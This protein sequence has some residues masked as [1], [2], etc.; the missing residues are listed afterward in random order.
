MAI[1]VWART[2]GGDGFGT[3][4]T[5]VRQ[6]SLFASPWLVA[7]VG[8]LVMREARRPA[9]PLVTPNGEPIVVAAPP[10]EARPIG[11][12]WDDEG[13]T[14]ESARVLDSPGVTAGDAYVTVELDWRLQRRP[15]SG[16]AV[17]LHVEGPKSN[18]AVDYALLSGELLFEDAPLHK[19]LRDVSQKILVP[20]GAETSE[21]KIFV[22][23]YYARRTAGSLTDV[24]GGTATDQGR[25][26]VGSVR[27]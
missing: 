19:T 24:H 7:A 10:E 18:V 1:Y 4:V 15:P 27:L 23:L 5:L 3:G 6:A 17:S 13:I 14:L 16:L 21:V 2:R 9:P 25:V 11:A 26:L 8:L 20:K 22:Q 12:R